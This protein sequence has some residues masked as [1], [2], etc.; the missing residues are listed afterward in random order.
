MDREREGVDMDV[1]KGEYLQEELRES[2]LLP[3]DLPTAQAEALGLVADAP[4][5]EDEDIE[6]PPTSTGGESSPSE[7]EA[8]DAGNNGGWFSHLPF[9]GAK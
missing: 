8:S 3:D 5:T 6:V 4:V 7:D 1:F 9:V 2:C